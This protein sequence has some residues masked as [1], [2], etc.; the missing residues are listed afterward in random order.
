MQNV[1]CTFLSAVSKSARNLLLGFGIL[2]LLEANLAF[3]DPSTNASKSSETSA[4]ALA[5]PSPSPDLTQVSLLPLSEA[6][7]NPNKTYQIGDRIS[8]LVEMKG[9]L[10]ENGDKLSLKLPD[11]SSKLEEQ[12]WYVDPSTQ[13]LNGIFR[14]I[15]SPIQTGSLT[16]PTLLITKEDQTVIGRTATFSIQVT[17]PEKKE[18][19]ELIDITSSA[20][21]A[22]YWVLFSLLAL[23]VM[24]LVSYGLVRFLKNRRKKPKFMPDVPVELDHLR[25]IRKIDSFYQNFPY[26][27]DNLKPVA[28][29]VSETLK[30]FFSSRFKI[31]A[32]EATTD[33]MIELLRKEAI[34][35]ENLREIQ[36]L[37]QDLD[38][39]K[40]T[41]SENYGHFDESKYLDLKLKAQAII[42]KWKLV[43]STSFAPVP[44]AVDSAS[45]KHPTQNKGGKS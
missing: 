41:K 45:T 23:I 20:L 34:T 9:N 43:V 40:F 30:E 33:E 29:G 2:F 19:P 22:K 28:F 26:A 37:F 35:N 8:L 3:A 14:F 32:T 31:D 11:G 27:I 39:V 10:V 18:N 4:S 25:A 44:S 17:G 7:K 5:S 36:L 13:Y 16:L 21:P 24:G 15:A 6:Q 1:C 38:L 42:L 12:G